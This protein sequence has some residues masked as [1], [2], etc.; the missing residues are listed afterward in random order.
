MRAII[1][2]VYDNLGTMEVGEHYKTIKNLNEHDKVVIS[3][4]GIRIGAKFF[5][6][7]NLLK[8]VPIEIKCF[9]MEDI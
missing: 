7:P 3:K 2:N 8:K 4:S 5:F 9:I 6:M 1:Y